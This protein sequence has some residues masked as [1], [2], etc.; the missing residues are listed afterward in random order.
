MDDR[1]K[2]IVNGIEVMQAFLHGSKIQF[3][4]CLCPG[5]G[6]DDTEHP[7]WNWDSFDYRVAP[8][9]APTFEE[10]VRAHLKDK[11]KDQGPCRTCG[12]SRRI[13]TE[14]YRKLFNEEP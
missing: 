2:R 7:T 6:W 10:S 4:S 14:L 9:P 12:R 3:R 13:L 8:L 5:S 1:Y 11:I